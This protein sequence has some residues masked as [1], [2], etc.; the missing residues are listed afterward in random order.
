M[1]DDFRFIR[2][3][4]SGHQIYGKFREIFFAIVFVEWIYIGA[5]SFIDLQSDGDTVDR[6]SVQHV[7]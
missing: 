4:E 1:G 7:D 6:G 2:K 5:F 3:T